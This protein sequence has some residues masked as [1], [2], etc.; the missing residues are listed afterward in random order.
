ML[1]FHNPETKIAF[2]ILDWELNITSIPEGF[3]RGRGIGNFKKG[4]SL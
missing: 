1:W 4:F 2:R 3:I